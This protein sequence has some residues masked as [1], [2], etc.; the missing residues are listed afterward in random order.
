MFFANK[1]IKTIKA[2]EQAAN[3]RRAV[4]IPGTVWE[5]PKPASVILHLPGMVILRLLK[6]GIYLY[7]SPKKKEI[8][9]EI[10][11]RTGSK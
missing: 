6:R 1:R 11:L 3:Q 4:V 2:L 5:K 7:A 10:R 8:N 9:H